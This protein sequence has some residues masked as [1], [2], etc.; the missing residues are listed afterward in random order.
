V[1][2]FPAGVAL[3]QL[4]APT[5]GEV[6]LKVAHSVECASTEHATAL[7]ELVD[8]YHLKGAPCVAVMA[9]GTYSLLQVDKPA[10]HDNELRDA[11]RWQ[12]KDLLDFPAEQ[13]VIDVF[14]GSGTGAQGSTFTVAAAETRV[15]YV[16]DAL[17]AA[18]LQIEAIDI[19]ELAIRNIL[20]KS[21]E[22]ERGV[23]LLSLFRDN[24]LITIVR[25]GELCMARR[26]NLGT[27]ELVAASNS[28]AVDGVEIS[29]EQQNILDDMVLEIQRS[30]DY[31]ESS[32]SRQ[33]VSALLIAPVM[34]P[35]PGLLSYLDSYLTP[36]VRN[37]DLSS[38]L[39]DGESMAVLEQAR[40]LSAIGAALR[41]DL[42]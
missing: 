1:N 6:R 4:E 31:Y 40:C 32:V 13:A 18:E 5:P 12:I 24:G 39:L 35:I 41:S 19:P 7:K 37:L 33:A 26:I 36:E 2:F 11:I 23:A 25:D 10:V 9:R 3:V 22:S 28:D 34:E 14:P 16:V 27:K 8:Q 21:V 15:R 38:W 20:A 42:W 29:E 17:R 30:L